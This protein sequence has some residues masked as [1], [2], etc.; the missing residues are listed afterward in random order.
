MLWVGYTLV[1]GSITGWWPYPFIDV[2]ELGWGRVLVNVVGVAVL[3]GLVGLA[4][5]G[6]DRLLAPSGSPSAG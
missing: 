3:F 2:D 4:F 1:R 5:V 6:A